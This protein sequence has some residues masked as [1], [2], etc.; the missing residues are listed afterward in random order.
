MRKGCPTTSTQEMLVYALANELKVRALHLE[1]LR[2]QTHKR[3]V[4]MLEPL[5]RDG[6]DLK[7]AR[8]L[9][10]LERSG[11]VNRR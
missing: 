5:A 7:A 6:K 8:V 4:V 9:D 1:E 3:S 2:T 11:V 10:C